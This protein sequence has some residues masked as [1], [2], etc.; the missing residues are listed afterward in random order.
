MCGRCQHFG[1]ERLLLR[2]VSCAE[3]AASLIEMR[4]AETGGR[5]VPLRA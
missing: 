1:E 5:K 4:P 3:Q 2:G